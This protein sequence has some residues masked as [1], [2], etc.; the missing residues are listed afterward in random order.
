[1]R[2]KKMLWLFTMAVLFATLVL[3]VNSRIHLTGEV[4]LGGVEN[5]FL[6]SDDLK[7]P[8]DEYTTGG[9]SHSSLDYPDIEISEWRYLLINSDNPS[10]SY[11][12]SVKKVGNTD[13]YFASD[14]LANLNNL[15]TAAKEA[16]FS[17]Y[18][19]CAY[20]SYSAQQF[21]FTSKANQIASDKSCSYAEAVEQAK[22]IV[23]Y[24]GTSDHQTGLGVD[25]LDQQYYELDYSKMDKE[26]FAWMYEHCAEYGFIARYPE[27]KEAVT[28]WNEPWHF[29]YVGSDAAKFIME[30][31]LCLEEFVAHYR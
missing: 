26:F 3:I 31:D 12:P 2:T 28:G 15:I 7:Q 22:K 29:R 20:R 24:P 10:S 17:P 16:G 19:Y 23:A 6:R 21:V 11:E 8:L 13:N 18:I 9:E 1:M 25:I 5:A 30:N 14:A 27:S 4:I